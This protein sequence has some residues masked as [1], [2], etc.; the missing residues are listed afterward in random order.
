MYRVCISKYGSSVCADILRLSKTW[1][2]TMHL[3]TLPK[4]TL[5]ALNF[6]P[7]KSHFR[8]SKAPLHA[9]IFE[10]LSRYELNFPT[11]QS[12][13][14]FYHQNNLHDSVLFV[15]DVHQICQSNRIPQ[16]ECDNLIGPIIWKASPQVTRGFLSS[17]C[18]LGFFCRGTSDPG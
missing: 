2:A 1:L 13:N 12:T 14:I 17:L 4:H 3:I 6:I 8:Y 18:L 15:Y 7:S 16:V 10:I 5:R 11:L 9:H